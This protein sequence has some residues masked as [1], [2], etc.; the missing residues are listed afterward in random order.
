MLVV[1]GLFGYLLVCYFFFNGIG[2]IVWVV[3]LGFVVYYFGSVL[4]GMF[5]NIK[6]YEFMVFGGLIVLGLLFW[7]W[8]CFKILCGNGVGGNVD[9]FE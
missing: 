6:K 5:G 3:V 7:L 4:E 2:V 9:K 1:I 8:W